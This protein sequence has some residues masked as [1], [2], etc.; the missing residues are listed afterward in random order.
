M[1]MNQEEAL[2]GAVE[3]KASVTRPL[4]SIHLDAGVA[5]TPTLYLALTLMQ[6]IQ[7]CSSDRL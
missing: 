1:C 7:G 2:K 3:D 5:P 6:S 4:T